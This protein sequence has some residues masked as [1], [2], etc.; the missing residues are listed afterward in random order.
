MFSYR[1]VVQGKVGIT[2][3]GVLP[4]DH[5]RARKRLPGR[6]CA[7]GDLRPNPHG[8]VRMARPTTCPIHQP[9]P[10][11]DYVRIRFGK[12]EQVRA[13]CRSLPRR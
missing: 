4:D 12:M 10:V 11:R 2:E 8:I 13:H 1:A 3:S 9:V 6:D 7:A 5:L